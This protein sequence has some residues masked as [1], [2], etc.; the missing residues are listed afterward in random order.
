VIATCVAAF[1]AEPV[2]L[3]TDG[4]LR[5]RNLEGLSG[6]ALSDA[7]RSYVTRA[8]RGR[9]DSVLLSGTSKDIIEATA[10]HVLTERFGSYSE[11]ADFAT[12]L[13]QAF[14]A[15]GL[16]PQRPK[17]EQPGL[18]GARTALSVSIYELGLAVNRLRNKAGSGHGRPFL[19][20]LSEGEI[21]AAT[22]AAGL[23]AGRLLDALE[24]SI[25]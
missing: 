10:A 3:T 17:Q 20:E 11:Q 6:R 7:L 5:P 13:G 9:E 1:E 22:E 24:A 2:E 8:A 19:P 21:R 15:V 14:V 4:L 23:V 25:V 18:A 16:E 12:L